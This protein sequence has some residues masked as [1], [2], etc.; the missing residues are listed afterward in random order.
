MISFVYIQAL[1]QQQ[2][3]K[4]YLYIFDIIS[5]SNRARVISLYICEK[6][7]EKNIFF[8]G[9]PFSTYIRDH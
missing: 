1:K 6:R 8:E 7:E 3:E 4:I 2:T 9:K 5:G